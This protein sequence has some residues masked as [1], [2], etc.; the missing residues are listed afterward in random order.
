MGE[1]LLDDN[2]IFN[3]VND[4]DGAAACTANLDVNVA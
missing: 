1:G 4:P 2:R 3:A